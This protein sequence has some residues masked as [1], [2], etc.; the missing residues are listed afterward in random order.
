MGVESVSSVRH[1]RVSCVA[2]YAAC[3][4][5]S[6]DLFFGL[7]LTSS[8]SVPVPML[9]ALWHVCACGHLYV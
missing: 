3:G 2:F 1:C 9:C 6:L 5:S 8:V 7:D 4:L